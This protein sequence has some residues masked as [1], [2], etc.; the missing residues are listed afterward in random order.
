MCLGDLLALAA[1]EEQSAVEQESLP[2]PAH[3]SGPTVDAVHKE[4]ESNQ[5]AVDEQEPPPLRAPTSCVPEQSLSV[6]QSLSIETSLSFSPDK[7]ESTQLVI[8][9]PS[10]SV[11]SSG[12]GTVTSQKQAPPIQPILQQLVLQLQL[13]QLTP[14]ILASQLMALQQAQEKEN[15]L[16]SVKDNKQQVT[17]LIAG[18]Q[19]LLQQQQQQ[20]QLSWLLSLLQGFQGLSNP[21]TFPQLQGGSLSFPPQ[22]IPNLLQQLQQTPQVREQVDQKPVESLPSGNT[23]QMKNKPFSGSFSQTTST[24]SNSEA[25]KLGLIT[26]EAIRSE[27]TTSVVMASPI[28]NVGVTNAGPQAA[29]NKSVDSN[30]DHNQGPRLL[31]LL[32]GQ[33]VSESNS[34]LQQLGSQQNTTTPSF[35]SP[36]GWPSFS[37][38]DLLNKGSLTGKN[39][40]GSDGLT[41][42]LS[43]LGSQSVESEAKLEMQSLGEPPVDI[44]LD[45][46]TSPDELRVSREEGKTPDSPHWSLT[47]KTVAHIGPPAFEPG[48][49][50]P[51]L[52]GDEGDNK[53]ETDTKG[54]TGSEIPALVVKPQTRTTD[55]QA[56][57]PVQTPS[58]SNVAPTQVP[59]QPTARKWSSGVDGPLQ[60]KGPLLATPPYPPTVAVHPSSTGRPLAPPFPAGLQTSLPFTLPA[61]FSNVPQKQGILGAHPLP[62]RP[63]LSGT[64]PVAFPGLLPVLPPN[65]RPTRPPGIPKSHTK[66]VASVRPVPHMG[67]HST[68]PIVK[69]GPRVTTVTAS[70]P[71]VTWANNS[72]HHS[73]VSSQK[74]FNGMLSTSSKP[75]VRF[76]SEQ[77]VASSP[78]SPQLQTSWVLLKNIPKQVLSISLLC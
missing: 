67:P 37:S 14:Q 8:A 64:F 55:Y 7:N 74:Q 73:A 38:S 63:Q 35:L 65:G 15:K 1:V 36:D 72:T 21:L 4:T 13:Q 27:S 66:S 45:F 52:S 59:Q 71:P 34:N 22:G 17:P 62:N 31:K 68:H 46:L 43:S 18:A 30:A 29:V 24:A 23:V 54:E 78:D 39:P 6:E 75:E 10:S 51:G 26:T 42:T 33:S 50:W 3:A 69:P 76:V 28:T 57:L 47:D 40:W 61:D 77:Q 5:T 20:Q 12:E 2:S 70:I 25:F 44:Q 32:M 48:K 56:A 16:N 53:K 19:L 9:E 41:S 11:P 58:Q 49:I 60:P